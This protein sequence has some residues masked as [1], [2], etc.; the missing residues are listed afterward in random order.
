MQVSRSFV[1]AA[2]VVA[3][4]SFSSSAADTWYWLSTTNQKDAGG[5]ASHGKTYAAK[6]NWKNVAT[7][8]NG[9][10]VSGDFVI[11]QGKGAFGADFSTSLAFGGVTM[12]ASLA[13]GEFVSQGTL[14]MQAGGAGFVADANVTSLGTGANG[15]VAYTGSGEG[16]MDIRNP[17]CTFV[18]QKSCYGNANITLV[19]KGAGALQVNDYYFSSGEGRDQINNYYQYRKLDFGGMKLQEGTFCALLYY[20][21]KDMDFQFDGN[22]AT[23]NLY[24]KTYSNRVP[25]SLRLLGGKFRETANCTAGTHKVT[26]EALPGVLECVGTREDT[27]FSGL[28][29]GFAGLTWNPDNDVEFAFK[30]NVMDT[31]GVFIVSNGTIRVTEGA[32]FPNLSSV[33]V[34]GANAKFQIDASAGQV[35]P[36]TALAVANG[37]KLMLPTGVH[38]VFKTMTLNGVA[39][40][41]GVYSASGDIGS[42]VDWIVG[43]GYAVI[44]RIPEPAAVAATWNGTGNAT[45]L[46]NWNGTTELPALNDGSAQVTVA[47]GSSFV[48]DTNVWVKGF[49]LGVSPFAF[50]AATGKELWVGSAG[51]AN[52]MGGTGT[53]TF[54]APLFV[55]ADQTWDFKTNDVLNLNAAVSHV[56]IARRTF[57]SGKLKVNATDALGAAGAETY[58]E[59][60]CEPVFRGSVQNAN[61]TFY[62]ISGE[63]YADEKMK[64]PGVNITSTANEDLTFNGLVNHTNL[65]G[66]I[67]A[68]AG[69]VITFNGGLK[70]QQLIFKGTGIVR[71]KNKPMGSRD[72]TTMNVDATTLELYAEGNRMMGNG[73]YMT[74]GVIK[75]MVPYAIRNMSADF[76][77]YPNSGR[78]ANTRL[79]LTG[80]KLDLCGNDQSV[81]SL[82]SSGEIT[83]ATPALIHIVQTADG[84]DG[85]CNRVDR[86]SWTGGA[87][88]SYE[89]SG[90]A[91]NRYIALESSS[92]GIVQVVSGQVEMLKVGTVVTQG[93]VTYTATKNGSW[94]NATKAV[95]KGGI[96]KLEHGKAFGK[97]TAFELNFAGKLQLEEGVRQS[98]ASL[99]LNGTVA[100]VGTYGSTASSAQYKDDAYFT[101][102]GVLKVGKIGEYILIR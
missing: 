31:K 3:G 2:A 40:A 97:E 19:K 100:P 53:F 23:L 96:L 35:F 28:Y 80:T 12:T 34:S 71:V 4:L 73:G 65:Q 81:D 38:A 18:I 64:T 14:T 17:S 74:K 95:V 56:G 83:S 50:G 57:K 5:T 66:R 55:A 41:D 86:S 102:T 91:T 72:R 62:G 1:F 90:S 13:S 10:P 26:A 54:D 67:V 24:G 21:V 48:A 11:S 37:G 93:T 33:T 42:K 85:S 82:Y 36:S 25:W 69:S 49:S 79:Y 44:G 6:A 20:R 92:T 30:R 45:T 7:G 87:G 43:D 27:S 52:A 101:G 16:V 94:P 32:S 76:T 63:Q 29:T 77:F 68:A 39:V 61:L 58:I 89:A 47:G 22:G 9:I 46:A 88:F 78:P 15:S 51:L 60:S 98:C 84:Y 70:G 8:E 75:T 59:S 99:T